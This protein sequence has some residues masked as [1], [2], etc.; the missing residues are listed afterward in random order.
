MVGSVVQKEL[1][2][3]EHLL[4]EEAK[5]HNLRLRG[6]KEGEDARRVCGRVCVHLHT[7]VPALGGARTA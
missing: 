7:Q 4:K 2:N 6:G 3:S 1:S 5:I